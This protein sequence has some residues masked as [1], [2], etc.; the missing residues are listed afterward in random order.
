MDYDDFIEFYRMERSHAREQVASWQERFEDV[1]SALEKMIEARKAAQ[2]S[3]QRTA[4][5]CGCKDGKHDLFCAVEIAKRDAT[6][7]TA[8]ANR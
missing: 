4:C 1:T 3:V 2:H 6:R 8:N 7:Q 5:D